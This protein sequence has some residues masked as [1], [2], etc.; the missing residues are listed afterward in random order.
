MKP[1]S[2]FNRMGE[3]SSHDLT[4]TGANPRRLSELPRLSFS[5]K[6]DQIFGQPLAPQVP[7][8]PRVEKEISQIGTPLFWGDYKSIELWSQV[9]AD[10]W[11][12]AEVGR[13]QAFLAVL[14]AMPWLSYFP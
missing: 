5:D 11:L 4:Y 6:R 8:K 1:R 7:Y 12:A 13:L 9:F 14:L 2:T 3:S 10:Y